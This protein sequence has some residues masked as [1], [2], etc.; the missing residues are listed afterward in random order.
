MNW[1]E[2]MTRL[3]SR[4]ARLP[5]IG[6][7]TAE[8]MALGLLKDRHGMI[9]DLIHALQEVDEQVVTCGRCGNLTLKTQDPCHLCTD[10]RRDDSLLCVVEDPMSIQQM[11]AVGSYRGRYHCLMGKLSPM[12][13]QDI[14]PRQLARLMQRLDEAPVKE[15]ILAFDS[16]VESDASSTYLQEQL[17]NKGVRVTRLAFGIPAGSGIAYADPITLARALHGRQPY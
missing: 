7:R 13:G 9:R 3:I 14:A 15:V 2:P 12:Q 16:D 5:G 8:R 1:P 17:A 6:R 10:P 11:E 4:L